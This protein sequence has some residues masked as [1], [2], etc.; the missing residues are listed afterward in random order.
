VVILLHEPDRL[1]LEK[2]LASQRG[3]P[4]SYEAVG[5]TRSEPPKGFVVD[6]NRVLLGRGAAAYEAAVSAVRQWRMFDM[7]WLQLCWP[8]APIEIGSTVAVVTRRFGVWWL[9]ACRIVYGVEETAPVTR[10]GFAY[11]TLPEHAESGEER[12]TVEWNPEDDR[13]WYDLLAFSR[14]NHPLVWLGYPVARRLQRRFAID[15]LAAMVA[16]VKSSQR[17]SA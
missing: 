6:H 10:F 17:G 11:G 12:F 5:A 7:P 2:F 13:V 8:D 3:L 15:S 4:F 9:N 16:A 14:P 1:F